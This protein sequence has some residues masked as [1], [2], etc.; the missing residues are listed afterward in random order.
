MIA[1]GRRADEEKFLHGKA[2]TVL[3]ALDEEKACFFDVR[4][5]ARS[6][7]E[8]KDDEDNMVGDEEGMLR[9]AG[10][11]ARPELVICC[12]TSLLP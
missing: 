11:N 1:A 4:I 6:E 5:A 7:E 10:P 9:Q 2:E 8:A 12:V 3:A